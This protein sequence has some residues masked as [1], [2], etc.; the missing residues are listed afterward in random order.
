MTSPDLHNLAVLRYV[1]D[2]YLINRVNKSQLIRL[3]VTSRNLTISSGIEQ[4]VNGEVL[5]LY[6][7]SGFKDKIGKIIVQNENDLRC[8]GTRVFDAAAERS[9][10]EHLIRTERMAGKRD[11]VRPTISAEH[12]ITPTQ[13]K[14]DYE[15]IKKYIDE[16]EK[17]K[18]LKMNWD[19][20]YYDY[21]TMPSWPAI[22]YIGDITK[23][24]P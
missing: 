19:K 15:L 5:T 7:Y 11:Y 16:A 12:K 9:F 14:I 6:T 10:V 3:L 4:R 1:C 23:T 21:P 24:I 17:S 20:T 8:G 13:P 2:T 18:L 22:D